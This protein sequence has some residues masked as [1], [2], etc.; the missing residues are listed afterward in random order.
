MAPNRLRNPLTGWSG[1]LI[2][3]LP[4]V[5]MALGLV[6]LLDAVSFRQTAFPTE[7]QVVELIRDTSGD[8]VSYAPVV[9]YRAMDGR[10]YRGQT[11]ISSSSYNY[12]IGERVRILYAPE[13]TGEVRIDTFFSLYGIG[14]IFAAVG[15]V[16]LLILSIARRRIARGAE[17]RP[18]TPAR[19]QPERTTDPSRYGHIHKPKPKHEPT[20]RRMR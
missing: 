5:V 7:G 12:R 13:D 14:A 10:T 17:I 16:F 2:A 8:G 3:A 15:A 6:F 11:H 20:V 1:L 4:I 19:S 18:G 9:E